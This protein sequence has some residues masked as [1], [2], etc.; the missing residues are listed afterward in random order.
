[1]NFSTGTIY[2]NAPV[3]S[4]DSL[5]CTKDPVDGRGDGESGAVCPTGLS[6]TWASIFQA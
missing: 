4:K 2:P 5:L 1:M 3:I 6:Q